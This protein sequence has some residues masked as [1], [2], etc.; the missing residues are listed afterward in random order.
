M[1]GPRTFLRPL[2][3]WHCSLLWTPVI[4]GSSCIVQ[5]CG[6]HPRSLPHT[7]DPAYHRPT[8]CTLGKKVTTVL[9]FASKSARLGCLNDPW[10]QGCLKAMIKWYKVSRPSHAQCPT[11]DIARPRISP[12]PTQ[13][14]PRTRSSERSPRRTRPC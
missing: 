12:S 8:Y 7:L 11:P 5:T 2:A 6:T 13:P 1:H 4:E 14:H 9:K 10:R 3:V